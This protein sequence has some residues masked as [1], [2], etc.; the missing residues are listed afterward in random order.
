M[1]AQIAF[2]SDAVSSLDFNFRPAAY[3]ASLSLPSAFSG[4]LERK[5]A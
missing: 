3:D 2:S 5:Q 4:F 1:M